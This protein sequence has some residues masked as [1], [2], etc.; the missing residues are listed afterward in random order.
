M[1]MRALLLTALL[2]AC[3]RAEERPRMGQQTVGIT[4][5]LELRGG[6]GEALAVVGWPAAPS[7]PANR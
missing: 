5:E 6:Q 1:I 2:V 4:L 3:G 7:A